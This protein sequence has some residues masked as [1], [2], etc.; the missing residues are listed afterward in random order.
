MCF[1][2]SSKTIYFPA[3]VHSILLQRSI[4]EW[5]REITAGVRVVLNQ[6]ITRA[7]GNTIVRPTPLGFDGLRDL[8]APIG[9]DDSVSKVA[10]K[11]VFFA[12]PN[13]FVSS[14]RRTLSKKDGDV[15][16]S[17]VFLT[18]FCWKKFKI[19][20][21]HGLRMRKVACFVPT[22]TGSSTSSSYDGSCSSSS[23][24]QSKIMN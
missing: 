11:G 19:L 24:L 8:P 14:V 20:R 17:Q 10:K 15:R 3:G 1:L 21:H 9:L 16:E 2:S 13:A 4:V 12:S 22:S 7:F 23:V 18:S 5:T 6:G